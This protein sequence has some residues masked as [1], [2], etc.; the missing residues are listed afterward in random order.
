LLEPASVST[1]WSV[2]G[3]SAS[4]ARQGELLPA[5]APAPRLEGLA[6]ELVGHLE[7]GPR[8]VDELV[9]ST[10]ASASRVQMSLMELELEGH[11][12]RGAGGVYQRRV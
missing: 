12:Q 9:R 2:E 4:A 5:S 11:I 10:G 3:R 8:G 1:L 7:A 6:G